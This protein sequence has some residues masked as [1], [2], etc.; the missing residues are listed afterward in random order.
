MSAGRVVLLLVLLAVSVSALA[1]FLIRAA[2]GLVIG[3]DGAAV[4]AL[5]SLLAAGA[6][7]VSRRAA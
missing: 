1:V 2:L 4:L 5:L 3:A 6:V 7:G